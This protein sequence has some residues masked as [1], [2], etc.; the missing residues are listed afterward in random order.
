MML[1]ARNP[2]RHIALLLACC[3]TCALGTGCLDGGTDRADK[4]AAIARWEDRR[5]APQDSL[6]GMLADGDAHVRLAAVRAAGLIG[7]DD[8]LPRMI[9]LREDPSQTVRAQMLFSLGLLA[10]TLAVPVLVAAITDPR[11]A[12]RQA[13]LRGLA[14]MPNRGAALVQVAAGDSPKDR[15]AAWDALRNQVDQVGRQELLLALQGGLVSSEPDVLWRVLRCVERLPDSTLVPLVIPATR[16]DRVQVRVHSYRALARLGGAAARQAVL[17]SAADHAFRRLPGQRVDI[18]ACR[19]LGTLAVEAPPEQMPAVAAFLIDRSGSASSHV[20]M[21]ALDAMTACVARRPLPD[22]AADQESLLPVWRIRMAR[23]ALQ[24]MDHPEAGVRAAAVTA[25]AALRGA[26][27]LDD[28]APRLA[29][30]ESA[31][32]MAALTRA[33]GDLCTDPD[34]RL[35][36]FLGSLLFDAPPD[37]DLPAQRWLR[38]GLVGAAALD[39]LAANETCDPHHRWQTQV[40]LMM[41]AVMPGA[42]DDEQVLA[43]T[44]L[45]HLGDHPDDA[46]ARGVVGVARRIA[47]PWRSDLKLAAIECLGKMF[48]APDSVWTPGETAT[49]E[50]RLLLSSSFDDP[51]VRIRLTARRTAQETGLLPAHLIPTAASLRATL[52]AFVRSADQP[53]VTVQFDAPRVTGTTNRGSFTLELKPDVAP[54]TCAVFLDLVNRGFYAGLTF[55]RVVPDFVVQGGDPTGTGWGSSGYTI[56]SE[57]SDLPYHRGMVGIAHSGKDTGSCQWFVT[58]SE[59][60]HLV[61]RYTVFAEV[62]DG[63]E[64]FDGMQPGDKFNLAVAH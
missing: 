18:A 17:L 24:R 27:S 22:E 52:P 31:H 43:A 47:G 10:D 6:G 25:R 36:P 55:H 63:L 46:T 45:G 60:P 4:L 59:Q 30:E 33:V 51:D 20:A 58:L 19:A 8:A 34:N 32:V 11:P 62:V 40:D 48:S 2:V 9:D 54:N 13:A 53:P 61:W 15:A 21:A 57:W 1:P 38:N 41:R 5:L 37:T 12:I 28:F 64:I 7:R 26:G 14:Q 29:V 16:S 49:A 3:L 56:R 23:A 39:A 35:K 42:T 44:A 50:T